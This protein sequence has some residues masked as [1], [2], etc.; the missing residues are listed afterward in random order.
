LRDY[1]S[2]CLSLAPEEKLLR[3]NSS[4]FGLHGGLYGLYL[5]PW[6]DGLGSSLRILFFD[7]LIHHR[8]EMLGALASWLGIDADHFNT[9]IGIENRSQDYRSAGIQRLA[10]SLAGQ[11]ESFARRSPRAYNA[12]R[13]MYLSLNGRPFLDEPDEQLREALEA[14]YAPYNRQ[15]GRILS[16]A[17]YEDLPSWATPRDRPRLLRSG[18]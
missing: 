12:I 2:S 10:L 16:S 13:E 17:G 15:L 5:P 3:R 1:L 14:F 8:A 7:D 9:Q 11:A 4:L 18:R 6:I